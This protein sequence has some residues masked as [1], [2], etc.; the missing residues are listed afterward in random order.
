[1]KLS[2][3]LL[4]LIAIFSILTIYGKY[5]SKKLLVIFKPIAIISITLLYVL[6]APFSRGMAEVF[7]FVGLCFAIMGDIMLLMPEEKFV[8]GLSFFALTH[9]FY[10]GA[11]IF[12]GGFPDLN[13]LAVFLAFGLA[14]YF[15]LHKKLGKLKLPVFVYT[16]LISLMAASA[17]HLIGATYA[18]YSLMIFSGAAL[19]M[20]SDLILAVNK[21]AKPFASAEILILSTYFLGQTLIA[22]AF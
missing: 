12:M 7:V 17:F 14:V 18:A 4:I 16:L 9:I 2:I 3:I 1:M 6:S 20:I 15:K 5:K 10:S 13:I 19:F 11:F 8:D 22:F 21:F